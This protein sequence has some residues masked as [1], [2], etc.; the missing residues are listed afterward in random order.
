MFQKNLKLFLLVGG[1]ITMFAVIYAINPGLALEKINRL[2]YDTSYVFLIRHWGI[3]VGL[4]GFFMCYSAYKESWREPI[5]LFSFIEKLFM[6][7]L[8]ISNVFDVETSYLN[9]RFQAFGITDLL[10]V[11]YTIGYWFEKYKSNEMDK[12]LI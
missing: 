4:M 8:Y 11:A 9:E 6:V 2:P 10:I 7:Y 5:I 3:M 12:N 1:A